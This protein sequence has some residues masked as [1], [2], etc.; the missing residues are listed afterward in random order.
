[1]I[2]AII[3]PLDIFRLFC[4]RAI[5]FKIL[6]SFKGQQYSNITEELIENEYS[7]FAKDCHCGEINPHDFSCH[8]CH[9][10]FFSLDPECPEGNIIIPF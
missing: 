4:R 8:Q 9:K 7:F 10:G 6:K 1:M 2:L 5:N 3:S